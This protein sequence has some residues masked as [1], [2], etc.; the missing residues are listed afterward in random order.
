[1]EDS[2]YIKHNIEVH[3]SLCSDYEAIHGEIFNPIEQKR[4]YDHLKRASS[5]IKTR[6]ARKKALDYGCGTGNL[7]KHFIELNM[8]VTAADVAERFLTLVEERYR[9][10][11]AVTTL[12]LNGSDLANVEDNR[13]DFIA[14]YSVLHHIPNYLKIVEEMSRTTK[15]G[16][17][18]YFDHE[19][20]D[21]CWHKTKD[22][23]TFLK[24]A[25]K[26]DWN[27]YLKISNYIN[28]L[29]R[30]IDPCFSAEGDIHTR[31]EDHIDWDRI[32][33]V[34][35]QNG[36]EIVFKKDYLLYRKGYPLDTYNIY[37]NKCSDMRVLVA[38]KVRNV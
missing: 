38:R 6:S 18:I 26:T 20:N 16:G 17:I 4:L 12:K 35:K 10:S 37:K 11:G 13:F 29:H 33:Q 8:L 32:E 22:Y 5:F 15:P 19:G 2:K 36:C 9:D 25:K 30:I 7:T 21:A 28:K 1:M 24:L 31:A 14:S 3:N 34:L 27:K 23:G